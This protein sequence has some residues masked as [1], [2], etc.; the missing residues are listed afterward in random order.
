MSRANAPQQRVCK[1]I[2]TS[3]STAKTKNKIKKDH[4]FFSL[5]TCSWYFHLLWSKVADLL[6][7][8][9]D[10]TQILSVCPTFHLI[11][12]PINISSLRSRLMKL[13]QCC[14]SVYSIYG[15]GPGSGSSTLTIYGSGSGTT[16]VST[17]CSHVKRKFFEEIGTEFNY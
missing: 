3:F 2:N 12:I 10:P 16:F 8:D 7:S 4:N 6:I 13:K 15:S 14:G 17:T 9:P 1:Q 11:R 5:S